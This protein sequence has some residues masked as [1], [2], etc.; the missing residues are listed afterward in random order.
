MGLDWCLKDKPK[1][2]HEAEFKKLRRGLDELDQQLESPKNNEDEIS[3]LETKRESLLDA[4]RGVAITPHDSLGTPRIGIDHEAN[5]WLHNTWQAYQSDLSQLSENS[6]WRLP[7]DEL[8]ARLHGTYASDLS[9]Y[10]LS[11][12]VG[13][14]APDT[15]FRGKCIGH[16]EFLNRD[17]SAEAYNDHVPEEMVD[18]GR[19][20]LE[21]VGRA[22]KDQYVERHSHVVKRWF[23]LIKKRVL[24][25]PD[26]M[27]HLPRVDPET[28][29][30]RF[31][32][33]KVPE[34][35][36]LV[37]VEKRYPLI[38]AA[39]CLLSG[40]ELP[41]YYQEDLEAGRIPQSNLESYVAWR[42]GFD[43]L[44]NA[45]WDMT[46]EIEGAKWLQFWGQKGHGY[47]AWY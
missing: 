37:G 42:R 14:I 18:Y 15:S 40:E 43:S 31:D 6:E 10:E 45:I 44:D 33:L 8:L 4:Y 36:L 17:L 7:Y 38:G 5:E 34:K 22:I 30:N 16:S 27:N 11:A 13:M 35:A 47:Y 12:T 32:R 1:P 29:V 2:G 3:R 39:Q 21:D 20:I 23:G 41:D 9:D 26:A 19:R 24:T 25:N 46:E 28:I